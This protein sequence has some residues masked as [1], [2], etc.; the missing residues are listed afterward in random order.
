[1]Y[2]YVYLTVRY[3]QVSRRILLVTTNNNS[4]LL[5]AVKHIALVSLNSYLCR[6][7]HMYV[8]KFQYMYTKFKSNY[9]ACKNFPKPQ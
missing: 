2:V 9:Y 3:K 6:Y 1:M 8:A 5:L 4:S 7:V